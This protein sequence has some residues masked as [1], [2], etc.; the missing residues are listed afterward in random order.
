MY[1]CLKAK[2]RLKEWDA[3]KTEWNDRKM[4][5]IDSAYIVALQES[6][7]QI[8]DQLVLIKEFLIGTETM[9]ERI[10][11]GDEYGCRESGCS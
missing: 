9:L 5:E 11:E 3:I 4:Q 1:D 6:I 2:N 7:T 10:K 8:Q